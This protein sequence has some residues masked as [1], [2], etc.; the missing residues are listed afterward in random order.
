MGRAAARFKVRIVRNVCT[1]LCPIWFL[2]ISE[3]PRLLDAPSTLVRVTLDLF[4]ML[5]HFCFLA[6]LKLIF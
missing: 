5:G 4:K 6:D 3:M 1:L 2:E